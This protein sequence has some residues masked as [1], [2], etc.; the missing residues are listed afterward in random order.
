MDR[1][2]VKCEPCRFKFVDPF[3][4][5]MTKLGTF[6]RDEGLQAVIVMRSASDCNLLQERLNGSH[7]NISVLTL[8]AKQYGGGDP[9]T[10]YSWIQKGGV[11]VV[12]GT[13]GRCVQVLDEIN[14][15]RVEEGKKNWARRSWGSYRGNVFVAKGISFRHLKHFVVHRSNINNRLIWQLQ[16][17][18][19]GVTVETV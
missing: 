10:E 14:K 9:E 16:M 3:V 1:S 13:I 12:I 15:K 7:P 18:M 4:W 11:N 6:R 17:A 8:I 19:G 2:L 5:K